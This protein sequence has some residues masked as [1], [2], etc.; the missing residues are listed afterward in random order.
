[1]DRHR[2]EALKLKEHEGKQLFK[3]F[4]IPITE[5]YIARDVKDIRAIEKPMVVKAQVLVGGR[6][7]AGGI[8]FASTEEQLRKAVS[9]VLGM[10]IGGQK[11]EE[12]LIEERL[13][14]DREL[15]FSIYLDRRTRLP[16]LMMIKEGGMDVETADPTLVMSWP[17]NPLVGMPQYIAREASLEIILDSGPTRHLGEILEKMW[18]L[19]WEMDC[20]LLEVNP[21]ALT[22]DGS[23]VAM[24]AKVVL[25]EDA[26]YRH[27]DLSVKVSS[28]TAIEAEAREKGMSLV[29]LDGDVGVIANGAGLTMATLD[30]LALHG[31]KGAVF[32]D[33][34][35]TDDERVVEEAVDLVYKAH[36]KVILVNIFGGITKCDTVAEGLIHA[37]DR[38]GAETA[39]V[40][41]L[42]GVNEEKAHE[43]LRGKGIVSWRDL[44]EACA[45]AALARGV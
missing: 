17:I 15:Y 7:K 30:V 36:P 1:M 41:R 10:E 28:R 13:N 12:V 44:D 23:M 26:L 39:L 32:L 19:F 21:L 37:K 34:G 16:T 4:G 35:G 11:V 40:V 6:G 18:K 29:Q 9:E 38:L 8:R 33:L 14:V 45:K 27:S 2:G 42:R 22:F 20:E 31:A 43:M 3:N 24:D 25:D 5:G